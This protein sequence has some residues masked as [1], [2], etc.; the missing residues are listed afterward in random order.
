MQCPGIISTK[1]AA[2]VVTRQKA[3][4]TNWSGRHNAV[5]LLFKL[6][7]KW[8]DLN[9]SVQGGQLYWSFPF[10]KGSLQKV[11]IAKC[12]IWLRKGLGICLRRCDTQYNNIW[13]KSTQHNDNQHNDLIFDTQHNITLFWRPLCWVSHF[14]CCAEWH[15]TECRYAECRG[16]ITDS[17]NIISL[18]TLVRF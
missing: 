2:L 12:S 5:H 13:N 18:L 11:N 9:K 8:A 17:W 1:C 3:G 6:E 7:Q 10:S 16:A 15:C 14:Y 4:N